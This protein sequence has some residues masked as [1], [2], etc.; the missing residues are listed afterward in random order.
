L[1]L[2]THIQ[3]FLKS[4]CGQSIWPRHSLLSKITWQQYTT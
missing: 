3:G 4:I 2:H 1:T